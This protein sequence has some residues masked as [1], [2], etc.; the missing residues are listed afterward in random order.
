MTADQV[1]K[2]FIHI[3]ELIQIAE[4]TI[5]SGWFAGKLLRAECEQAPNDLRL[6]E[7]IA[8]HREKEFAYLLDYRELIEL[9]FT[10]QRALCSLSDIECGI[11]LDRIGYG[12]CWAVIAS[13]YSY[14]ERQVK[15]ICKRV[16]AVFCEELDIREEH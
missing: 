6:R 14:S 5:K 15:R 11:L 10:C 16:L 3:D 12:C 8:Y 2:R 7:L 9:K 13:R 4:E 1:L